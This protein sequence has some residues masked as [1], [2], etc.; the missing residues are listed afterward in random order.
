GGEELSLSYTHLLSVAGKIDPFFL[1]SAFLLI[2]TGLSIKINLFPL[3][4]ATIDAKTVAPFPV[5]AIA[6]TALINGGFV[7][8]FRMYS[9]LTETSSLAWAQHVLIITG[10]ISL[11]IVAIQL[12]KVKRFKRM[13]AFS[14]ME[15]MALIIIALSLGKPG[16]YA[17]ILHLVF[18]TLIKTGLFLHFGIIRNIYQSGWIK[19]TGEYF[20]NYGFNALIYIFGILSITAIPPS[21]MFLSEFLIFKGLFST[22]RYF[23][24]IIIFLLLSTII[25]LFFK[26]SMQL[27]YGKIESNEKKV[28][29]SR[30]KLEALSQLGLFGLVVYLAYF[31]PA[32][33]SELL[34]AVVEMLN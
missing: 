30:Y 15:H 2:I 34:L 28:N 4:A 13:F 14:S 27:L 22:D 19:E 20:K 9:V 29:P 24:A 3:H 7:A 18:H 32:F 23:I 16:Y 5:N 10:I 26:N 8:Y 1:K 31:P 21:G 11:F 6:S 12:F 33:F 25:Y 17:A